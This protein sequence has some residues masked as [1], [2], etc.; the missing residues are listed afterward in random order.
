MSMR[1][2]AFTLIELLV[3]LA[4]VGILAALIL[5][6]VQAAR[7]AG[8]RTHCQNNLKQISGA[9]HLHVEATKR[10]PYGGW[11]HEWAG[12]PGRG[13][14]KKQPGGWIYNILPHLELNDLHNLGYAMTG[15]AA[16]AAY[17][18]RLETPVAIFVCPSRRTCRAWE[19]A[20]IY[21]YGGA[22]RPHGNALRVGRSDYAING[23]SSQA[24]SFPGPPTLEAGDDPYWWR[25]VHTVTD[26]SGISHLHTA[27]R[28]ASVD[29]GTSKT[30]LV[31]EKMMDPEKYE[32]GLSIGDNDSLYAGYSNDRHRFAGLA[33]SL[34]PWLP[35]LPDGDEKVDPPGFLRFGSAHADGFHMSYCDG[36]V[37]FV[38]YDVDVT[39]HFRAGHRRDGGIPIEQIN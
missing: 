8:R 9:I 27:A 16:D 23:G 32:N 24:V 15:S 7:E 29:D 10:F 19:V 37:H 2:D 17:T 21:G 26:V 28:L 1:R 31:G 25:H 4:I 39:T 12:V 30:Y 20:S 5:P 14:G 11:G 3:V 18:R 38:S 36:S 6:A 13:S 33:G 35:P 22:P 34:P